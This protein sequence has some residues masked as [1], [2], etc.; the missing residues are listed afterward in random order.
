MGGYILVF[1]DGITDRFLPSVIP[2]VIPSV[3]VP[4]HCTTISV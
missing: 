4:H 2:S 1:S 3:T